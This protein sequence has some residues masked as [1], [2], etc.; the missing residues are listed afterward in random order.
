MIHHIFLKVVLNTMIYFNYWIKIFI[1]L[2][3]LTFS[4]CFNILYYIGFILFSWFIGHYIRVHTTDMIGWCYTS[5]NPTTAPLTTITTHTLT[6]APRNH[7]F[8]YTAIGYDTN[9]AFWTIPWES[10]DVFLSQ[11]Q[12]NYCLHFHLHIHCAIHQHHD[13]L[14]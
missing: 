9:R 8:V 6:G 5:I 11:V 3:I 14:L 13:T 4:S 12:M 1:Y 10:R 7:Y 2:A